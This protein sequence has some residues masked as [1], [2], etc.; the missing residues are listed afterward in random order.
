M[1]D[2]QLDRGQAF[3]NLMASIGS[4]IF[5]WCRLEEAVA[6]ALRTVKGNRSAKVSNSFNDQLNEWSA[7]LENRWQ[8]EKS[9]SAALRD[10]VARIDGVRSQRNLIVHSFIGASSDPSTGDPHI[11]CGERAR[12]GP[13][14]KKVTQSELSA[15]LQEIDC[16]RRDVTN[17]SVG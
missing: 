4:L 5:C 6:D 2:D 3:Q 12:S 17:L 11:T 8:E 15:L 10:L 16:C 13:K 9:L 14:S 7:L 1:Q